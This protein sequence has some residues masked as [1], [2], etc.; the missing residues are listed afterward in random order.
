MLKRFLFV[1]LI[2]AVVFIV[3]CGQ[4][5]ENIVENS[6]ELKISPESAELYVGQT[7]Q[8]TISGMVIKS[9]TSYSASWEVV[10]DIGTIDATGLFTATETGEGTIT[11]AIDGMKGAVAVVVTTRTISGQVFDASNG[12]SLSGAF[13]MAGNKNT[14]SGSD[15]S[16]KLEEVSVEVGEISASAS[17]YVPTTIVLPSSNF[18]IPFLY[19]QPSDF[20]SNYQSRTIPVKGRFFDY[21]GNPLSSLESFSYKYDM[22][23][24]IYNLS[25]SNNGYFTGT[26]DLVKYTN[27]DPYEM[28]GF[29]VFM[30]KLSNGQYKSVIKEFKCDFNSSELDLGDIYINKDT[31]TIS[32]SIS[33]KYNDFSIYFGKVIN[34]N[35]ETYRLAFSLMQNNYSYTDP[36]FSELD[37]NNNYKLRL[38]KTE[39]NQDY[40]IFSYCWN[41]SQSQYISFSTIKKMSDFVFNDNLAT[42]Y[43]IAFVDTPTVSVP[44]SGEVFT[45]LTPQF[46]WDS[47]GNDFYY[48]ILVVPS[49]NTGLEWVGFTNKTYIDY[50]FFPAS[51]GGEASNLKEGV[52]YYF[53]I[54]ALKNSSLNINNFNF[55]DLVYSSDSSYISSI[56]FT[57]SSSS[58]A[59]SMKSLSVPSSLDKKAFQEK[60]D[61]FLGKLGIRM[62]PSPLKRVRESPL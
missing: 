37:E 33:P 24:G 50:P 15:G 9:D 8:F 53:V 28:N 31:V 36:Y 20:S 42:T 34:Q 23:G 16:Y 5:V 57:V 10:G 46:K 61:R 26:A 3:G 32:G 7:Q 22:Y 51:S 13:I 59:S 52:Q 62:P 60:I 44:T 58:T 48:L 21:N 54:A 29:I 18:N 30:H 14:Y 41:D 47:L 2:I 55:V 6:T 25:V 40:K 38:P 49:E 27:Y 43:N 56:P 45:T 19:S 1:F 12:A 17:N 39:D 4:S 35:K 11:V